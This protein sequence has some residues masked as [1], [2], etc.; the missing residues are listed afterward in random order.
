MIEQAKFTYSSFE[1]LGKQRKT[2]EEQRKKQVKALEVLN[3]NTQSLTIK[4]VTP[5]NIVREEAKSKLDKT[6]E[7]GTKVDSEN[8]VCWANEYTYSFS[9]IK[10]FVEK[11]LTVKFL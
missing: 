6:T 2:N 5:E 4:G 1:S 10:L 11:F 3:P 9:T 8:F 7:I